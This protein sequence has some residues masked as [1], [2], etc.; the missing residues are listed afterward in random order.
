MTNPPAALVIAALLAVAPATALAQA[1]YDPGD[2]PPLPEL[3][4]SEWR[5]WDYEPVLEQPQPDQPGVWDDYSPRPEPLPAPSPARP[6]PY[7]SD[8]RSAWLDECRAQSGADDR[9]PID[10]C[11]AYLGDYERAYASAAP[12]RAHGPAGPGSSYIAGY[13]GPVM[14]VKVPIMRERAGCGCSEVIEEQIID[15][16]PAVV[17]RTKVQ[18]VTPTKSRPVKR[19]KIDRF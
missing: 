3:S 14:W 12:T 1:P 19:A 18:P 7:A 15:E 5:S 4:E 9:G 16:T 6:T 2:P 8:Q 10:R 11:E 13:P 17:K